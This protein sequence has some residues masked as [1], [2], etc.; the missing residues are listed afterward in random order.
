M[1]ASGAAATLN[2]RLLLFSVFLRKKGVDVLYLGA[3]TPS[4]G[5]SDIIRIQE[6]GLVCLSLTDP[7]L[8]EQTTRL[9]DHLRE[10]APGLAFVLGGV[11][12]S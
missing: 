6:V 4:T 2:L 7:A 12:F 10:S 11:G 5:V 1:L 3:D 9:M 8:A